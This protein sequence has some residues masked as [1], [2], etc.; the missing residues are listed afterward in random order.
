M[1]GHPSELAWSLYQG[2]ALSPWQQWRFR[3]HLAR[4][5]RCRERAHT[6]GK[7]QMHFRT[8][9]RRH[10]ELARL[11]GAAPAQAETRR[12]K[13]PSP[14]RSIPWLYLAPPLGVVGVVLLLLQPAPTE[15]PG[16]DLRPKGDEYFVV[17]VKRGDAVVPLEEHCA[18]GDALRANYHTSKTHLLVL[19]RAGGEAPQVLHP[20]AG[21]RS[22]VIGE[23]PAWTPGSWVIDAPPAPQELWALLSNGPISSEVAVEAVRS[24]RDLA[25]AF[26]DA[27]IVHV[28]CGPEPAP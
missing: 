5:S 27:R 17:Y 12:P 13:Q 4:C 2:N 11:L 14:G 23:A 18:P 6:Q 19:G 25:T 10:G 21:A 26:P 9:P 15:P 8:D 24:D 20:F 28:R 16:W 3:G 7:E 22:A 1:K